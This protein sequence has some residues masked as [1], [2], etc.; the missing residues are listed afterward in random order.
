MKVRIEESWNT[1]LKDIFEKKYFVDLVSFVKSEYQ[2]TTVYPPGKLIF[3]A[4]DQCPL[5]QVKVVILGQDP[6]HGPGQAHGLS[7]SVRPGVPFPPSLLNIFKEIKSD[8]GIDM[9]PNGDLT[10]WAKQGVFLL[11]ATLTV[12]SGQAGSHQKHGWEE[13]TDTVIHTI[14]EKRA[15]V[16]FLL[17]G[18]YAGKKADLID[19]NKHLVLKA[20]HPSPLSAHRGFLGCRHFSQAN[21]YLEQ[22]GIAPIHW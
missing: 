9:P 2:S 11:N 6:Y 19:Q 13:F 10:R 18:A 16:V 4:F 5:E 12:R 7:F 21:A 15:H 22:N 3:N 1:A 14:S 8:L 17:W 20:P